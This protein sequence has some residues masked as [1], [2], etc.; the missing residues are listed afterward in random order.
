MCLEGE[1]LYVADTENHA[2][3]AVDLKSKQVTTI[4]GTGTQSPRSPLVRYSGEAKTS[5]ISSPWDVIQIPGSRALYIAMAGPHEIWKLDLEAGQIGVWAGSGYENIAD[6]GLAV[7]RFAQPSG[8]ATDGKNLFVADSEVSGVR[9]ITGIGTD[10]PEVGRIAGEGLFEF[11]DVDGVGPQ[12]RLQHCLGVAYGDGKLFIADTYNNK[13]KVADPK[14]PR[15]HDL[16]RH[17]R[18]RAT[19]TRRPGST[20]PGA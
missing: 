10:N 7:A 16:R 5:A 3:R 2:I 14:T 13:I 9:E 11:G 12:V 8:L 17:G 19:T 15:G 18:P 1:T 4:A 20:S 6:G